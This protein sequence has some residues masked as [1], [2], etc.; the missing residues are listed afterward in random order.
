MKFVSWNIDGAASV[1]RKC[2]FS[3]LLWMWQADIFSFQETK[4]LAPNIRLSFP[5]YYAYWS[6]YDTCELPSPQSGTVCFC[7]REA[8]KVYTSFPNDPEFDTEGRLIVLEYDHYYFINVYVP[9]SQDEVTR[10]QSEKSLERRE[11]REKF[12]TLLSLAITGGDYE[13][14]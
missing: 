5:G 4:V 13:W 12:D 6:F 1:L 14:I 11:Y 2:E 10:K 7:R 8:R 9:N 3:S